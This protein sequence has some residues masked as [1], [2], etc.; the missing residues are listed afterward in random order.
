MEHVALADDGGHVGPEAGKSDFVGQA[1]PFVVFQD[2]SLVTARAGLLPGSV[3]HRH[4][5]PIADKQ[6]TPRRIGRDQPGGARERQVIILDRADRADKAGN[7]DATIPEKL[8]PVISG[9]CR[10]LVL[11]RFQSDPVPD[12]VHV[13][14]GQTKQALGECLSR[15]RVGNDA[16]RESP[17]QPVRQ[18]LAPRQAVSVAALGVEH[19][20]T[21]AQRCHARI[22][23]SVEEKAV[24]DVRLPLV[25]CFAQAP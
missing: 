19:R 15:E 20:D 22:E 9:G 1:K 24:D 16:T 12:D 4:R 14:G 23:I 7:A 17:G 5:E 6:D 13:I 11:E 2:S 21:A 18:T 8:G 25:D 10:G 3:G